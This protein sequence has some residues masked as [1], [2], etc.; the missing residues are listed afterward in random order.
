MLSG[1][2]SCAGDWRLPNLEMPGFVT[3]RGL[4]PP[5]CWASWIREHRRAEGCPPFL[6]AFAH[7]CATSAG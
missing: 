1:T 7:G 5:T 4:G 6:E 3:V 2:P